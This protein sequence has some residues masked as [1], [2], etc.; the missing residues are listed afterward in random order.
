MNQK[1]KK[2]LMWQVPFLLLLIIGTILIIRQQ[3]SM[4]Y[5]T[6]KGGIFGTFYTVTYQSEKNF[7]KEIEAELMKV[8]S[9]LSMFN[10]HSIISRINRGNGGEA[11]KMFM[12]VFNKA[13]EVSEETDGAF[14][15]T[16]APLVNAWGFG[17]KNGETPTRQQVDSIRRFIGWKKVTAEGMNIK[18]SDRRVMLDCSAIAKGYGVDM[19]A[20]LLKSKG[21]GR[22]ILVSAS[23]SNF[24]FT[25]HK[26]AM[27]QAAVAAG[28]T[29]K[30][31]VV[32]YGDPRFLEAYN[33]VLIDLARAPGVEYMDIYTTMKALGDKAALLRPTDGVHL[34]PKGH[35]WVAEHEYEY[36]TR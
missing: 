5:Q 32:R 7:Q 1:R 15:I 2:Q 36:L 31:R 13:L 33:A 3:R 16:V 18:K 25:T 22:I 30:R 6:D 17:F 4:P 14:D 26:A 23:S 24:E 34:T 8:D 29:K 28:K 19:V 12:D 27:I 35:V 9:A 20:Q 10:E 11:N 21:I